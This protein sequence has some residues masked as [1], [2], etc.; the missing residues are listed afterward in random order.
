VPDALDSAVFNQNEALH[1][2]AGHLLDQIFR[3]YSPSLAT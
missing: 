2:V 1:R 3:E